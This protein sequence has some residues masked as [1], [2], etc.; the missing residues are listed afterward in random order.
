MLRAIPFLL[1]D[2]DCAD[3]MAF[4]HDRLGGELTL[5]SSRIPHE[6]PVPRR[7]ARENHQRAPGARWRGGSRQRLDGVA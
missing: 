6:E 3:A 7:Q 1:F 4:Y 5:T 2:G